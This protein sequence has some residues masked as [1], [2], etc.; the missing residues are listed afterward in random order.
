[1]ATSSRAGGTES[2]PTGQELWGLN[3]VDL[4][5]TIL[6]MLHREEDDF[7]GTNLDFAAV[8]LGDDG[9]ETAEHI[10][11]AYKPKA[12]AV[13]EGKDYP[14]REI[15]VGSLDLGGDSDSNPEEP[16][17]QES[18]SDEVPDP[19]ETPAQDPASSSEDIRI[20]I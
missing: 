16:S 9:E 1:M 18:A 8:L 6:D 20:Q 13:P 12:G 15:G 4:D 14:E 3:D 19:V 5:D 2:T 7:D 17:T 10:V 11:K